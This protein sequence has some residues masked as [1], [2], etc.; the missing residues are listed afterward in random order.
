MIGL[1]R[2]LMVMAS[3]V[4]FFRPESAEITKNVA[5]R[6]NGRRERRAMKNGNNGSIFNSSIQGILIGA[7]YKFK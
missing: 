6:I 1:I 7:T 4:S 2:F 3:V 5:T